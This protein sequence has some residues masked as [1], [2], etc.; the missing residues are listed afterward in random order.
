MGGPN[1]PE[2]SACPLCDHPTLLSPR[3]TLLIEIS[4]TGV[5]CLTLARTLEGTPSADGA[6]SIS[7]VATPRRLTCG[8]LSIRGPACR[9][10]LTFAKTR[11]STTVASEVRGRGGAF[12]S[13]GAA[14]ALGAGAQALGAGASG[15]GAFGAGG[16]GG[17]KVTDGRAA[18]GGRAVG[19]TTRPAETLLANA[20]HEATDRAEL[21][22][23]A[24]SDEGGAAAPMSGRASAAPSCSSSLSCRLSSSA[25][26]HGVG[27]SLSGTINS[28][29][30]ARRGRRAR[31]ARGETSR[32]GW[33]GVAESGSGLSGSGESDLMASAAAAAGGGAGCR[34]SGGANGGEGA[35]SV[36]F[37]GSSSATAEAEV[38]TPRCRPLPSL[39]LLMS[40]CSKSWR[41]N[42]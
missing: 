25:A 36:G 40:F 9:R 3:S 12:S 2:R 21:S 11:V 27:A 16:F 39:P 33:L 35:G 7:A 29:D 14:V 5:A 31:R 26:S 18:T 20:G 34:A 30:T 32:D 38:R 4:L 6:L 42:T 22:C 41:K 24:D 23:E 19:P 17:S 8:T 28:I 10:C 15:A 1:R 13:A 37:V